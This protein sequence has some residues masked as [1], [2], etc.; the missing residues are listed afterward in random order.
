MKIAM[1]GHKR[2]PGR[3][4]GIE[5]VVEELSKRMVLKG[6]SVTAYNR[7]KKGVK[8]PHALDG[9]KLIEIPT[10][11]KKSTD[12]V[13]YSFIASIRAS[14]GKYDVLHYHAIGPSFFLIIPHLFKKK[15]VV[16]V[17]GL[18][19]K[20]PKWKGF[21]AWFIRQ[22]EKI[23]AKYADEVIVLSSEQ[24]KYF[25]EKYNR[26]TIY[27][28]N[29]TEIYEKEQAELITEKYG[30]KKDDYILFLSRVVPGKGL[31]YLLDAYKN[32]KTDK[33]LVIAGGTEYVNE[34]YSMIKDKVA[35]DDRVEMIG[36]VDG[37]TLRELYSN[38]RLF[39]FPSE[40]EG[41]PMCLL[42]ALSYECPCLVSDIPENMEVGKSYVVSFES[43]NT[44][45]LEKKLRQ[46]LD[47]DFVFNK[48][49]RQYVIDN[50]CWDTIVERT[51]RCYREINRCH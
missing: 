37:K 3:E 23:V 48:G 40:A 15:V 36:Y 22:G 42:E 19:Y 1:L 13:V 12:A 28:P 17:H 8:L 34:F 39:V 50:F 4:G 10:I 16:T 38:A 18:N 32:I 31:E 44:D 2:I 30:I 24:K 46:C 14:F 33:K 43:K 47:E 11:E 41:M 27:I 45:D 5:V 20:T 26:E 25:K 21:G 6:H 29:G 35:Q 51:L 9:V 7:K 49:S